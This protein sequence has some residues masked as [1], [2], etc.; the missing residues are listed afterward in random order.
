[1]KSVK[2]LEENNDYIVCIKPSGVSSEDTKTE[3]MPSL[4]DSGDNK[5]F[6]VHRLDKE[7]SGVMVFAKS[8][9]MAAELSRQ[10]TEKTF[11]KEYLAVVSGEVEEHGIF[12]DLLYHDR[13]KNKTYTVKRERKGVK[14]AKLEFWRIAS[15]ETDKGVVSLVRVKLYT[16][17]THQIRVQFASRKHPI[18][19][20]MKYGS[21]FDCKIALFSR[22][23]GFDIKGERKIFT[24]TPD[25]HFPWGLF[26]K[27][28]QNF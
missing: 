27:N 4:L 28:L 6:V 25:L 16:G 13:I 3:G 14:P 11:Q 22:M 10:I 18:L 24:K 20:D 8:S 5:P 12:E 2:I 26:S 7:V 23:L 9:R 15:A 1:M 17:R 19:G 21:E